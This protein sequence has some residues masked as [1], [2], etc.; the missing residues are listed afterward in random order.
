MAVMNPRVDTLHDG[1]EVEFV[2]VVFVRSF[3][4]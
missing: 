2:V 3:G 1:R 4:D